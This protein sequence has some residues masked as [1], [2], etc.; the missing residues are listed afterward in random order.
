MARILLFPQRPTM[1]QTA[2]CQPDA[3]S[4]NLAT[5][6]DGEVVINTVLKLGALSFPEA[7]RPFV[8]YPAQK[9]TIHA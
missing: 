2:Q 6:K 8:V 7:W 5:H 3:D 1:F 9:S 4:H